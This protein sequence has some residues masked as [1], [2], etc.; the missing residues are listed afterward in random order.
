MIHVLGRKDLNTGILIN[1]TDGGEG[2]DNPSPSTR[3]K[4]SKWQKGVPKPPSVGAKVSIAMKSLPRP[5]WFHKDGVNR[6]FREEPPEGWIPGRI[7]LKN[8]WDRG[9]RK[10]WNNGE[11]EVWREECPSGEWREGRLKKER[12]L[13]RPSG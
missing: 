12:K 13:N 6:F 9:N 3:E 8:N 5:K 2:G 7:G 10:W 4:M 1:L 11:V